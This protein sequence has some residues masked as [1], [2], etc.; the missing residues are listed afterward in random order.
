[1]KTYQLA[2]NMEWTSKCN[3]RCL[4]CPQELI[5]K[6]QLMTRDTFAKTLQ[7]IS[8]ERIFRTVIAG[9]GEP[10]TH[11]DFMYFV[12]QIKQHP[13]RFD[14]VT[15]GQQLDKER[16]QHLDGSIDLLIIS[17]SSIQPEVYNHVHAKLD[18]ET[19]KENIILAKKL[20][21]KTQL[22][23]SLTPMVECMD[24]LPETIKWLKA[25]GVELLTMSPTL[26]NRGADTQYSMQ[27]RQLRKIIKDYSL[28]SQELDFIPSFKDIT[29]QYIKNKFKCVPRNSDLFISASGDYLYCYNN[30]GHQHVIG[31][32]DNLSVNDVLSIREK[33]SLLPE[34]CNG[35][36]MKNRYQLAEMISVAG[37][38]TGKLLQT[39][40]HSLP[41]GE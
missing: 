29:R 7:R 26:Y 15:N 39:S 34:L 32:V 5:Q 22:G 10:T 41:L 27:S 35:C 16:L 36:N 2:V 13:G 28:H 4:M 23:I 6:P 40:R 24:S 25:Q 1:M 3:A 37:H 12:S 11:P 38:Y 19:V 30:V 33:L 8:P 9:Y 31:H 17:F 14:L 18:H 21:K 20:F